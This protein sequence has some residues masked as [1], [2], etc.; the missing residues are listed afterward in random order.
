VSWRAVLPTREW[1]REGI[2]SPSARRPIPKPPYA[3]MNSMSSFG[4][5]TVVSFTP[6][7]VRVVG[8]TGGG[9]EARNKSASGRFSWLGCLR[10]GRPRTPL[11][12]GQQLVQAE[13]PPDHLQLIEDLR[14]G[15]PPEPI[16][17]AGAF[18]DWGGTYVDDESYSKHIDGR[19]WEELDRAYMITRSDALS[20]LGT[21]H[22]IS[23]FPVYLRSL[24]ED[25][26]GSLAAETLIP[27]L[28][29][30]GPEKRAG[31]KLPRFQ[32]LVAALTPVQCTLIATVLRAFAAR[33]VYE[34]EVGS[35]GRAAIDALERHWGSYLLERRNEP[36]PAGE[37]A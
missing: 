26:L 23:V 29:K 27:L 37:K 34:G 16:H 24:L 7:W 31:I 2:R 30:P 3:P 9:D 36:S 28:T 22:L 33:D 1:S 32:A 11:P 14:T 15:F 6:H 20:F 13:L 4:S 19:T 8:A 21:K 25:N 17:A 35:P 5:D 18:S 10:I 12:S